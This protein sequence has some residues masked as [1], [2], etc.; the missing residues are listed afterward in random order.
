MD[1]LSRNSVIGKSFGG[2][3]AEDMYRSQASHYPHYANKSV[4]VSSLE[5]SYASIKKQK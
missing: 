3:Q 2:S 1:K 4:M 5:I